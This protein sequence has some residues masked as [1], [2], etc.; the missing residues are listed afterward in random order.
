MQFVGLDARDVEHLLCCFAHLERSP[1][2]HGDPVHLDPRAFDALFHNVVVPVHGLVDG[3]R[4]RTVGAPDRGPDLGFVALA[5]DHRA[6]AVGEDEPR[7]TV[8]RVGCLAQL[9]RADDEDM[10][11]CS[12]FDQVGCDGQGVTESS[13]AGPDV[14]CGGAVGAEC[15]RNLR[16]GLRGLLEVRRGRDD[17]RVDLLGCDA[18]GFEGFPAGLDGHVHDVLFGL[19]E[20]P[21]LDARSRLNPLVARVDELADLVVGHHPL[22]AVDTQAEH[23]RLATLS[24]ADRCAHLLCSSRATAPSPSVGSGLGLR[25][26]THVTCWRIGVMTPVRRSGLRPGRVDRSSRGGGRARSR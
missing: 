6:R 9:L 13:A 18:T 15:V 10:P 23:F 24:S 19:G 5:D 11:G 14:E 16:G 26:R 8:V 25:T 1:A 3:V 21:V 12:G 20:A 22:R 17:D 2:E 4:L 7:R